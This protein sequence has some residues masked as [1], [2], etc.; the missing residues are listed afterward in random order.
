MKQIDFR[1]KDPVKVAKDN[2]MW[3]WLTDT[4][5][6]LSDPQSR[7][8]VRSRIQSDSDGWIF[9]RKKK[10]GDPFKSKYFPRFEF[11]EQAEE[12]FKSHEGSRRFR[13][14]LVFELIDPD[15]TTI[16]FQI[17][18]SSLDMKKREV[19]LFQYTVRE[20]D[21]ERWLCVRERVLGKSP[22]LVHHKVMRYEEAMKLGEIR[23]TT[24]IDF[25]RESIAAEM[26]G[27][28]VFEKQGDITAIERGYLNIAF[29]CY[30]IDQAYES[31]RF[32]ELQWG[33]L[34]AEAPKRDSD[35]LLAIERKMIALAD[36]IARIRKGK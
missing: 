1:N 11:C 25:E 10:D 14:S 35:D 16:F 4:S 7:E 18:H 12:G 17:C 13:F 26:N 28:V 36:S 32:K 33:P 6:N 20:F 21:N 3:I 22:P 9:S 2:D 15:F 29:G 8:N 34:E 23:M 30:G 24:D 19:P 27:K 5:P 31:I